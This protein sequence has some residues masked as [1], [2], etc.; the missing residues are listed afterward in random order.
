MTGRRNRV[1][2]AANPVLVGAVTTVIVAV[3]VF[4]AYNANSGLPF[5]PT[6]Q[7]DAQVPDAA[8]LVAGNEVFVGGSRVGQ[9]TEVQAIPGRGGAAPVARIAM[10]VESGLRPLRTDTKVLIRQKSNVGL[11]Y[12]ELQPGTGGAP[13]PDGGTLALAQAQRPVD[14]DEVLD[15]FD[16]P[17][18]RAIPRLLADLGDGFAGRGD[19]F[20]R[21]LELLPQAFDDLGVVMANVAD[22]RTDLRGFVRGLA[23]AAA[24]VAPVAR[25]LGDV[26]DDGATTFGA[27]AAERASF[28]AFIDETAALQRTGTPALRALT[29]LLTDAELLA[30]DALPSVRV[31]SRSARATSRG[32]RAA[33]PAIGRARV[34]SAPLERLL[35]NV[36]TLSAAPTTT[37]SLQRLTDVVRSAV[38]ALQWFNPI[39][40]RCNALGLWTRNVPSVVSEGDRFGTWFRFVAIQK[41]D[42]ANPAAAPAPDL[43]YGTVPDAGQNGE[44]ENYHEDYVPGQQLGQ[45]PGVQPGFTEKTPGGTLAR[46]VAAESAP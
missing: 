28:G 46:R 15:V 21:T 33:G 3:A 40:T 45:I 6:Y 9:V 13:L 12:V 26:F 38:P 30:R 36:R 16:P 37:G 1:A 43:H 18:R 24:T 17:T 42:E 11:K 25:E 23:D 27:I 10:Q 22:P 32:L 2:L 41:N 29:P 35:A 14:Q 5:V 8:E 31:V 39:Q 4:L 19:E 44:C 34:L 20:G 7:L